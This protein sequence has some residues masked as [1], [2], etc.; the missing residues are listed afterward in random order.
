MIKPKI[1]KI[2]NTEFRFFGKYFG[3]VVG[4]CILV[5]WWEVMLW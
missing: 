5:K 2:T 1:P 3:I 4:R